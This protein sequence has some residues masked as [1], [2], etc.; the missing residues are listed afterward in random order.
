[1]PVFPK[2]MYIVLLH[3]YIQSSKLELKWKSIFEIEKIIKSECRQSIKISACSFLSTIEKEMLEFE[4]INTQV[5]GTDVKT[6]VQ[7]LDQHEEIK[8]L[9]L[10]SC[11]KNMQFWTELL[12]ANPSGNKLQDLGF[13]I[14]IVNDD[15]KE[16]SNIMNSKNNNNIRTLTLY[17][18]YLQLVLNDFEESKRILQ[19][20]DN[21]R[22]TLE[23]NQQIF[24]DKRIRFNESVNPCIVVA[25]GNQFDLGTIS[26]INLEACRLL[27]LNLE[28]MIGENVDTLMPQAYSEHHNT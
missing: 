25:S 15:I 27:D 8:Q 23:A 21:I 3:S 4:L 26:S 10:T 20:V 16:C 7:N 11:E 6:M 1:M 13:Q 19:R 22:N 14:T 2:D 17:G 5:L 28:S 18:R 24:N 12:S 9:L